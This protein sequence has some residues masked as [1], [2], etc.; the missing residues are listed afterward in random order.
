PTLAA[1]STGDPVVLEGRLLPSDGSGPPTLLFPHVL[2]RQPEP[3]SGPSALVDR[4]RAAAR[5]GIDRNLPE[6]EASLAAGVLLG[7]AGHLDPDFRVQLQRSGLAHVVAI[8]GFKQVVVVSVL[9]GLA[10]RFVGPE[11]AAL[12][13]LLAI[14]AY[15]LL[16]GA[17]PAAVRAGIMVALATL[18]SRTGRL[19][20]PLTSLVVAVTIMTAVDPRILLDVGLQLSLSATL[21]AVLLWPHLQRQLR[22]VPR[23]LAEPAGL[24]LAITLATLPVALSVFQLV[25]VVSPVAHIVA[26]PLLPLVLVSAALLA[27]VSPLQPLATVVAWLAWL[28]ATLLAG[29]V[30]IFGSL[31]GAALSTGRLPPLAAAGLATALLLAGVLGL[32]EASELRLHLRLAGA[33]GSHPQER[34]GLGTPAPPGRVWTQGV[35]LLAC[36]AATVLLQV[37]RPDG[38][39]HIVGLPVGRGEAIFIRGPTGRTALVVGGHPDGVQLTRQVAD[40]LAVWEHKLHAVLQV[41]A[42]SQ[43]G[44]GLTLARYPAERQL[45]VSEDARVDLGGGAALDIYRPAGQE[46]PGIAISFGRV[47]LPL[48]GSPPAPVTSSGGRPI[49]LPEPASPAAGELVSDGLQVWSADPA[50]LGAQWDVV[51]G[52][53]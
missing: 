13:I 15:T 8:D 1:F 44:L 16:T 38:R 11:L 43:A 10:V 51:A 35:C 28:P 36:V 23:L 2:D 18:A 41:D 45:D 52:L 26:V 29:I 4:V 12:P 39:L 31:P 3:L 34:T 9:G 7:G 40:C 47:W 25:S 32:P 53:R 22:G 19:A 46:T 42:E 33:G 17:H 21:G 14:A 20:D 27:L 49:P 6:P 24:T 5:A 37:V 30:H 50:D 48:V